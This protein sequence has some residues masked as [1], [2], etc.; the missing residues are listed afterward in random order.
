MSSPVP[1]SIGTAARDDGKRIRVASGLLLAV[2]LATGAGVRLLNLRDQVLIGDERW[3]LLAALNLSLPE[4]LTGFVYGRSSYS[5]PLVAIYHLLLEAGVELSEAELRAPALICGLLAIVAVPLLARRWMG[6]SSAVFLAFLIALSPALVWYSR[7]VRVYMPLVL[8]S[9]VAVLVFLHWYQT[10]ARGAATLYVLLAV[11]SAYLH[12]LSLPFVV[13]PLLYASL[14]LLWRREGKLA[15]WLR[16]VGLGSAVVGGLA[17]VAAASFE[18]LTWLLGRTAASERPG[19][20]ALGLSALRLSGSYAIALAI[21]FYGAAVRGLLVLF[22][23]QP[24]FAAL[25]VVGVGVQALSVIGVAVPPGLH[26]PV[27]L[28]R[29][30]IVILPVLLAWVAVGLARPFVVLS[31][32]WRWAQPAFAFALLLAWFW[33]GPLATAEYRESSFAHMAIHRHWGAVPAPPSAQVATGFYARLEE[34][35]LAG[36]VIESSWQ[37]VAFQHTAPSYQRVHG[38]RVIVASPLDAWWSDPRVDLRNAVGL[39][40]RQLLESEGRHVV[41]HLQPVAEE[42]E[43]RG[44][45]RSYKKILAVAQQFAKNYERAQRK[46]SLEMERSF[47]PPDYADAWVQ[48]WD[49]E[50]VRRG[51]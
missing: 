21:V 22:R 40:P 37:D 19:P 23:E 8:V 47:G 2:A 43:A 41:V 42:W 7:I 46:L 4:I 11:A 29:Y 5:P 3:D 20:D 39:S 25:G 51:E 24:G 10:R 13:A 36:P 48:A 1:R 35:A 45:D 31:G 30:L 12:P 38:K 28:T 26:E 33:T 16:V 32:P 9:T 27:L 34:P 44:R 6:W 15:A 18:S 17:L 14:D 49:L 50:R